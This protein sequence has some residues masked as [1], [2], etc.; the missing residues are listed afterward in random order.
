MSEG[1]STAEPKAVALEYYARLNK[2]GNI[3]ELFT[4]D[5]CCFFPKHSYARGTPRFPDSHCPACEPGNGCSR[6]WP[7][8]GS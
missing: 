1:N 4:D 2:G 6:I 3:L 5:A 7:D 8:R